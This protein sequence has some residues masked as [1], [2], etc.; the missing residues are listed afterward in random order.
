MEEELE[1]MVRRGGERDEVVSRQV[2]SSGRRVEG[3]GEGGGR[4]GGGE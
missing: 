2:S 4:G 1:G 3:E